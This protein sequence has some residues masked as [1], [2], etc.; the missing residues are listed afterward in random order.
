MYVCLFVCL[1][2]FR[3]LRFLCL[4]CNYQLIGHRMLTAGVRVFEQAY[5]LYYFCGY[6][7]R[8]VLL[9]LLPMFQCMMVVMILVPF[10]WRAQHFG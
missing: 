7:M 1:S 5:K 4:E 8:V 3:P 6:I 10:F 9:N 2:V